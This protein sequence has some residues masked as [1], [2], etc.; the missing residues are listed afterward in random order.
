MQRRVEQPNRDWKAGHLAK[1]ANEVT[2]LQRQKF[3]QSLL[4]RAGAVGKNHLAH[5]RQALVA[6]KHVFSATQPNAFGAHRAR[7]PRIMRGVGVGSHHQ[8]SQIVGPLHQLVKI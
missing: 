8:P 7:H 3:F 5:A 6:E 1:D 4:A 2:A